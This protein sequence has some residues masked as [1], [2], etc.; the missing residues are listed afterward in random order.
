MDRAIVSIG[1]TYVYKIDDVPVI[2]VHLADAMSDGNSGFAEVDG[3]FQV[4]DEPDVKLFDGG[5]L[6]NLELTDLSEESIEFRNKK[7]LTLIKNREIPLTDGLALRVIDSNDLVYYPVGGIYDYGVHE[8]RGPMF[9]GSQSI[10]GRYGEY[11]SPLAARWNYKN[12]SA[13]Y[14][15]PEKQSGSE[16]LVLHKINGRTVLPPAAPKV[17]NGTLIAEGF[18]YTAIM[19]PREYDFE[20]WGHYYAIP[21]LGELWFAGYDDTQKNNKTS[22][23]LLDHEKIG[24][25]LI[26][27]EIIGGNVVAGNYSLQEGYEIRIRDVRKGQNLYPAFQEWNS[28]G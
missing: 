14:M 11:A 17:L 12:Y 27:S 1:G 16:T 8:I 18:Q 15:D 2:L 21:F 22:L 20:P 24:R 4:S 28:T 19:E 9:N 6:G 26:D 13:F 3:I 10:P 7:S 23:N 5:R 25:V